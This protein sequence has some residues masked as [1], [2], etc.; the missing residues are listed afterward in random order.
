M[1]ALSRRRFFEQAI[2][3][4][5]AGAVLTSGPSLIGRAAAS[6]H[7]LDSLALQGVNYFLRRNETQIQLVAQLRTAIDSRDLHAARQAYIDARPPYE[8]IETLAANFEDSDADIDARPYAFDGG[9]T[10]P[11]FRG[12]HKIEYFLFRDDD[13]DAAAVFA[14]NLAASHAKLHRELQEAERYGAASSFEGMIGL[15]EEIGSKKISSEEETWSDQS[16]LIFLSNIIGIQSQYRPFA[17]TVAAADGAR[18]EA[19]QSAFTAFR[20][21]LEPHQIGPGA[22][23]TPY[24]QVRIAER[25]L[26]SDATYRYRD[27]LIAAAETIRV[28]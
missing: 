27:A 26:F 19:V 4:S 12:F 6:T 7:S 3:T 13:L 8:E 21:L 20:A 15:A 11:D 1:K 24:S 14:E 28:I 5:A 18:D 9:E 25:K 23:M 16:V 17:E 22:A 2:G 10:S